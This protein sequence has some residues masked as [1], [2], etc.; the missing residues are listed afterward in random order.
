MRSIQLTTLGTVLLASALPVVG[1][2][3]PGPVVG[4]LDGALALVFEPPELLLAL[5][6]HALTPS[7][8]SAAAR[9]AGTVRRPACR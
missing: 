9:T 6:P 2:V 7:A 5:E 8:I 3:R 4:T 1:A